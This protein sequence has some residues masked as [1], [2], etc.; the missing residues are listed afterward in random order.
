LY[1]SLKIKVGL[2]EVGGDAPIRIQSMTNTDTMDTGATVEQCIRIILA[3]ADFVRLTVRN[4]KEAENLRNIKSELKKRGFEIPLIADVH[5]NPK[6]AEIS[7]GIADKVRI[8]PGNFA[9]SDFKDKL[10]SLLRICKKNH[11]AIRIGVNHGSL[12]ER[13]MEK[14]GDTPEG[15]V[16]SAMEYLRICTKESFSNVVVSLKSSNTRIMIWSNRLLVKT[17]QDEG[18]HF[19][20]HLGVTEAGEGEDGRLRSAAGI[21]T[22][23][24]EGIGDTIRISLTEDPENEIPVARKLVSLFG[25]TRHEPDIIPDWDQLISFTRKT[26]RIKNIGDIQVPVVISSADESK[27]LSGNHVSD[28]APDYVFTTSENRAKNPDK[29]NFILVR[30]EELVKLVDSEKMKNI[31]KSVLVIQSEP[32]NHLSLFNA[33][34]KYIR[35]GYTNPVII[36]AV[37]TDSDPELFL[38]KVSTE[39]GRYFIDSLADGIWLEN[40]NF[41]SSENT[42]LAFSLLQATRARIF[43]TE[44]IACPSCG[45]TL[46]D[47]QDTLAKVKAAT[48]HLKHLK[49]AVMGCIVNGPGEMADADYGFV[50]SAPGR[51]TLFKQKKAVKKNI[52]AENAINEMIHLI[53]DCNDWT[54]P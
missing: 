52:P 54:D 46:F 22:L 45:R 25:N 37:Y 34:N 17:M 28:I 47:I 27:E 19:P 21:G 26:G 23:L 44:Y 40:S 15:M 43:K 32:G 41:T 3:G 48:S 24:G 30:P 38:L 49:I 7:A 53:K 4:Q 8:N 13:I 5:F 39:I 10:I 31:G 42:H 6:I 9:G 18:M 1:L 2:S 14:Y 36:R 12:S 35:S 29:I 11:T 33:F 50:G 16:E 20:V 51:V